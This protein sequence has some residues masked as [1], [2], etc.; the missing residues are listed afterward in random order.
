M[1]MDT[2]V[3][4]SVESAVQALAHALGPQDAAAMHAALWPY[5]QAAAAPYAP[6][7]VPAPSEP[8]GDRR[9]R[10]WQYVARFWDASGELVA[11]TDPAIMDGTGN[12]PTI[13]ATLATQLHEFLPAELHPEA[14]KGRLPQLRNNLGRGKRAAL[15]I[16]YADGAGETCNCQVDVHRLGL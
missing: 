16:S 5:V 4:A 10:P 7:D 9:T 8:T 14:T 1:T 6:R 12:L 13:I 11:E 15:R 3:L 2:T